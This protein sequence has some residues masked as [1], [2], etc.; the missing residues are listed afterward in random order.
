MSLTIHSEL[1]SSLRT[2]ARRGISGKI[3]YQTP[4]KEV[5]EGKEVLKISGFLSAADRRHLRAALANLG[6]FW[7]GGLDSRGPSLWLLSTIPQPP[8]CL[9]GDS[10]ELLSKNFKMN[11][12]LVCHQR[13]MVAIHL[14]FI[15]VVERP[16][17]VNS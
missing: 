13:A 3:F 14:S 9:T 12:T 7:G 8:T 17:D 15:L 2:L 4:S 16:L 10:Q 11:I 1:P 6:S 5:W